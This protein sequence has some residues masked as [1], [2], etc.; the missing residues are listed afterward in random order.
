[1]MHQLR[2]YGCC[3]CLTVLRTF[4]LGGCAFRYGHHLA[5]FVIEDDAE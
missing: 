1:M 2:Q 5:A 3:C 4:P